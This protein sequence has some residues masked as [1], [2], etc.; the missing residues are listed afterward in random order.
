MTLLEHL[1]PAARRMDPLVTY[2]LATPVFAVADFYLGAPVRVAGLEDPNQ[3]AYYYAALMVCGVVGRLRPGSV[4]WIGMLESAVNVLLLVLAIMLPIWNLPT[5]FASGEELVGPFERVS[6][7]NFVFSGG[8][9]VTSF[10][11]HQH[12]AL[13][14]GKTVADVRR[15]EQ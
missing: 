10:Y 15:G 1:H 2:Y 14:G 6:L 12:R 4:P 5:A 3:R 7:V 11:R 8:A 9:F 13:F